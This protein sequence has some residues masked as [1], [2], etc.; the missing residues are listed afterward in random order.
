VAVLFLNSDRSLE[1]LYEL[2][3]MVRASRPCSICQVLGLVN[4]YIRL[5]LANV[6]TLVC[7]IRWPVHDGVR[8]LLSVI[9]ASDS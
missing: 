9:V 2:V 4:H 7:V 1:S 8:D 5:A 3:Y 6:S